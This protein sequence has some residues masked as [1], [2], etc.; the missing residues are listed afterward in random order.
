MTIPNLNRLTSRPPRAGRRAAHWMLCAALLCGGGAGVAAGTAD[1]EAADVSMSIHIEPSRPQPSA[2]SGLGITAEFRNTSKRSVL[3]L[4]ADTTTLTFPPE[5]EGPRQPMY[6]RRAF[7]PTENDQ[8]DANQRV[9][10]DQQKPVV[11]A[12][13]PGHS[14]R[15]VWDFGSQPQVP[16]AGEPKQ[17]DWWQWPTR[18]KQSELWTQIGGELRYLL[19]TP[20]DYQVLVQAKVG[21]NQPPTLQDHAYH[22][23]SETA[24]VK[25]GAPQFVIIVGA[26][27]GGL[28]CAF[29]VPKGRPRSLTEAFAEGGWRSGL[30]TAGAWLWSLGGACLLSAI[31]TILL[32][33]L[34]DSQFL[35]K[36]NVNDF[37]GAVV[38]GFIAQY[39]GVPILDKLIKLVPAGGASVARQGRGNPSVPVPPAAPAQPLPQ[40]QP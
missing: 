4:S 9:P 2:G 8:W 18:I 40:Q 35:V 10:A 28:I 32:A 19:F 17:P 11:I 38:V 5:I 34:S 31:V 12:I 30:R 29:L 6:G 39:A 26:M 13:R 36:I 20:G 16:A 24:V 25:V 27:L 3:Y 15:A 21:V 1:T 14:Y 7:F 22:T 23:V 37:W 33:R